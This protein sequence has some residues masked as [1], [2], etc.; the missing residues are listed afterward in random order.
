M[1]SENIRDKL[2]EITIG[3]KQ[4]ALIP[5]CT[6]SDVKPI[7]EDKKNVYIFQSQ[8]IEEQFGLKDMM[9]TV[10][11]YEITDHKKVMMAKIKYGI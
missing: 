11:L 8:I 9:N 4:Y 2:V 3:E 1:D 10:H 5:L 7:T 6:F